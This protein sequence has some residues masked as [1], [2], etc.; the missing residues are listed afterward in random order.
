MKKVKRFHWK[1]LNYIERIE[2]NL[3]TVL[4]VKKSKEKEHSSNDQEEREF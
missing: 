2:I 4:L 1:Y 3:T